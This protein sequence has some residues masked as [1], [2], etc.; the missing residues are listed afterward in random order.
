VD[1]E[2]SLN[3]PLAWKAGGGHRQGG[4]RERNGQQVLKESEGGITGAELANKISKR[5]RG[6]LTLGSNEV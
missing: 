3:H 4:R 5:G 2:L 6:P 1:F